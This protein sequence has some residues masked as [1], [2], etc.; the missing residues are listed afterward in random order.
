MF[1]VPNP[2]RLLILGIGLALARVG[3]LDRERAVRIADLSWPRI[4]T[5][6]ARMSKNAVDV[7]MVGIASGTVAITGV[8]FAG[9]YWGLAFA[10]GGGIAGGTIAL[11]SQRFGA[12]A[13]DELGLAVRSS[14]LL[15]VVA[16]LPVTAVFWLFPTELISV[17]SSDQGAIELGAAYLRIVGLGVPFAGLNLIGS[18]VLVGTDDAYTAMILRASGAVIN[19]ALNAVLIFGLDLG[20]EG[21]A[22]GTV[23]SNVVVT[24]AF[25]LGLSRGSLPGVGAFPVVVDP[26]GPFLDTETIRDL[27]KIGVPVMGRSLVWT[28]AEFPMLAI[29]DSFGPDVVAA[30]VIVRRIWGLMNTPGWGF[31]LASSSLVGQALGKDDERTA[32]AY[33]NEVIRYAVATYLISAALVAV[34]ARP[35]VLGFVDDP[36][37]PAVPIAIDLVYV[38]C[39]AVI[40][41]GV[42]GGSAGPLDASG[43]TRWTFGSQFV[44]MFLGSIPL[45][46]IGSVTSLGLTGLYLA[47]LAETTIPAVLNYYRFKTGTWKAV[48]R[49]YRP[50]TA[51]DD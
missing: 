34:F 35:I 23:L 22:L 38:A 21:A 48:S 47:F 11:V 26:F 3:L 32:E 9:P 49:S 31:G 6:I 20:V 10:L 39:L 17:L 16:T 36:A 50:K 44:G 15:T 19:I 8:G 37:A 43:D 45:T 4:V 41:Q 2:V 33:G 7:A 30:F 18:R 13:M 1:P 27:V 12:D 24:G 51:A 25:A 29:L 28:A 5:G 14:A 46:Y 40:L 42:S